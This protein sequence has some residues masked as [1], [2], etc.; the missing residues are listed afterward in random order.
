VLPE[1]AV[2]KM[3]G[4]LVQVPEQGTGRKAKLD[5]IRTAGKT[6]TTSDYRDAWFVGFTGNYCTAVWFGNDDHSPTRQLTGGVLPA[7]TWN[8]YMTFAH[9]GIELK[10]IPFVPPEEKP[11]TPAAGAVAA[12][13]PAAGTDTEEP[14][15]VSLSAAATDRLLAIAELL[16]TARSLKPVAEL[17]I[18]LEGDEPGGAAATALR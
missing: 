10:P 16:R 4:M 17:D 9:K 1:D 5:G 15:P 18:G 11:A 3:N 6:G 12:A 8:R 13:T 2:A 14:R 7:M